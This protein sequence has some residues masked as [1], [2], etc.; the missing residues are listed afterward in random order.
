MK[1]HAEIEKLLAV[2][3][4][5]DAAG[6]SAVDVHVRSCAACAARQAAYME[7]DSRLAGLAD[8]RPSARLSSALDAILRGARLPGRMPGRVP[9]RPRW[10]QRLLVPVGLLLLLIFGIW[11]VVRLAMP[12][13]RTLA[14]TPSVTPT[15][16][17]LALASPQLESGPTDSLV[18]WRATRRAE[19]TAYSPASGDNLLLAPLAVI[20]P[21]PV[22]LVRATP[23][24][25]G[26]VVVHR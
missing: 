23:F 6:R 13:E 16:T 15:A 17:P 19:S 21:T 2:Y 7:M 26:A 24:G 9:D 10:P 3:R 25:F 4:G 12:P 8:P 18:G 11:L 1:R 14:E 22:V 20:R 5:L